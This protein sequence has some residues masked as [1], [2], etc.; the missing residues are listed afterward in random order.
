MIIVSKAEIAMPEINMIKVGM[1]ARQPMSLS[2]AGMKLTSPHARVTEKGS[3]AMTVRGHVGKTTD[4]S[5]FHAP[6]YL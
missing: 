3:A 1:V 4:L 2:R 6:F 5:R